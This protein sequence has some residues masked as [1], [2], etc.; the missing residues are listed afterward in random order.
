MLPADAS[1]TTL[2]QPGRSEHGY[3]FTA[4]DVAAL[5]QADL[6]FYVGLGL[7][8]QVAKYLRDHAKSDRSDISF[9]QAVG[10]HAPAGT[11]DHVE[12]HEGEGHEHTGTDPHLWLDPTLVAKL[13]PPLKGA[14]LAALKR[15]AS[16]SEALTQA[17]AAAAQLSADIQT[18][19]AESKSRLAPLA[20]RAIVTHHAA[21]G[22]FAEH[23]GLRVVAVIRPIETSEPTK[24]AMDRAVAAIKNQGVTAIF[25]EPQ[26]NAAAAERLGATAGVRLATLDPVG[27]GDWFKMMRRNVESIVR[28]L[29]P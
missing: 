12:D 13:V 26:F 29:G 20:G 18:F 22:R 3:E 21:W 25:V 1:V 19:D 27:D 14:V 4:R 5:A 2:I 24:E 28:A 7:D 10:I 16:P 17:E 11:H 8:P 6:V 23:F 15:A 9:A